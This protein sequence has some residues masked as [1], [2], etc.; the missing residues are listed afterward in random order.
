MYT[1]QYINDNNVSTNT[2]GHHIDLTL[3]LK[4]IS[5]YPVLYNLIQ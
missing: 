1:N 2:K 5:H 4:T 3:T